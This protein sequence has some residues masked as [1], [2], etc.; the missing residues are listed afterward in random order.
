MTSQSRAPERSILEGV[1][2]VGYHVDGRYYFT[3]FAACLRAC[4][5]YLG[6]SYT[7]EYI[8]G[9]SGAA[10]RLM[11][12][13]TMWDGGN[14][15]IV[16]MAEDMLEPVRRA[17]EATGHAFEHLD[18]DRADEGTFRARIVES[19]VDRGRPI[20]A[21]GVIGPPEACIVTGYDRGG[22]ILVGWNLFQERPGEF[23]EQ[24]FEPSGYFR[25]GDWFAATRA[26]FLIGDSRDKPRMTDLYRTALA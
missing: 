8:M 3:P 22:D 25:K 21:L 17:F 7:Y 19:I 2:K 15:D 11:W 1:E 10:F 12:N 4:M 20:L 9:M 14:V 23:P 5:A 6:Q 24:A 16:F 18:R 13:S 26:L